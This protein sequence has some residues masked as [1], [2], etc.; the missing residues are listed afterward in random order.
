M[1]WHV[2]LKGCK[3]SD[4]IVYNFSKHMVYFISFR[5][6]RERSVFPDEVYGECVRSDN[7]QVQNLV[8]ELC[9]V[10]VSGAD[11]GIADP[12]DVVLRA[13]MFHQMFRVNFG[14]Y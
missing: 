1:S 5:T 12:T 3:E 14:F 10:M 8:G 4:R 6:V 7:E 11:T 9:R 2:I 13:T